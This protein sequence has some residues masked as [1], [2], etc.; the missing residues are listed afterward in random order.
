MIDRYSQSAIAS[1][2]TE[3]MVFVTGPRQIGKTTLAKRLLDDPRGYLSWDIP[4]HRE[5]ILRRE[6]PPTSMVVLDEIHK[7][8]SWRAYLK[9]L[10]DQHGDALRIL[11]TGSAHLD[12]Y[13]HGGDSLQG[14]YHLH[15]LHPLSVAELGSKDSLH[16]LLRLGGFPEPF[17][18]G[19]ERTAHRWSR[20]YRTRIVHEEIAS[21]EQIVDLG[22][23]ELLA[24]RL[25]ELVGAPL[26][27]NALREDLGVSHDS[28][29]RWVAALERLYAI[30]RISPFGAP[31]L[32]AIKKAQKHYLFD[33][34]QV[35]EA[36]QRFENLV[37][38][39]LLKWV[40]Y[41]QDTAGRD[42]ELRYFRDVDR[43]E[44]DFV[45]TDRRTP[46]L[47]VE[48]KWSDGRVDT[49]LRYL[50]RRF[51]E[52]DAWQLSATGTKDVLN[53]DGIRLAPAPVF[54]ATLV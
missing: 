8:R 41:E 19:S 35:P 37:A 15:R 13:R 22:N 26:S 11:V 25:P 48:A 38:M 50:K 24:L 44:V 28:V 12:A 4:D 33:W 10:Y 30:V 18:S 16:D 20:E 2:L 49:S 1:D 27:L 39:A 46:V 53:T 6:I 5:H 42:L 31:R 3:K 47:L 17:L 34:T 9:G 21:L 7:Y 54:L 40:D 32:R 45:V 52:A 29:R 14:R 51:P 43:R 36:P 23:L